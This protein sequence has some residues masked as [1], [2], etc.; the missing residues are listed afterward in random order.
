MYTIP[1]KKKSHSPVC[2]YAHTYKGVCVYING[3]K[4]I[5]NH[6]SKCTLK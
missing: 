5:K 3:L 6:L 4:I 2:M 1:T